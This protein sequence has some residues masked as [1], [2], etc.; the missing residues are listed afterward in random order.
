MGVFQEKKYYL[1]ICNRNEMFVY[2]LISVEKELTSNNPS[3]EKHMEQLLILVY[4]KN[5]YDRWKTKMSIKKTL[6][7][8]LN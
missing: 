8:G 7:K 5:F 6:F 1:H 3:F 4:Q 2:N